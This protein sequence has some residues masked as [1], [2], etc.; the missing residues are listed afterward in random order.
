MDKGYQNSREL[1]LGGFNDLIKGR[2][3]WMVFNKN[4]LV[5][6]KSIKEYGEWS[7]LEL[8]FLTQLLNPNDV[9]IEIGS[10]IGMHTIPFS[11]ILRKGDVYGFEPQN[12]IFQNLCANLSLNSIT[13]CICE[14]VA[15]SDSP[16]DK[17]YYDEF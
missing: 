2:Y 4:D 11:K 1:S 5:I 6:G 14:R 15:I 16:N 3:G 9:V 7:Q 8:D 17:L 13:N 12:I 10:N